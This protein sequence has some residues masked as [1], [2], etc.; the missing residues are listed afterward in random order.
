MND[1]EPKQTII[2]GE[3]EYNFILEQERYLEGFDTR[4]IMQFDDEKFVACVWGQSEIYVID[5]E[6]PDA[7]NSFET[8]PTVGQPCKQNLSIQLLP[9]FDP[10]TFPF[11][12]VLSQQSLILADLRRLQAFII[13]TWQFKSAPHNKN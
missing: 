11:A 6:K 2:G 5:R 3:I 4:C 12:F 1:T 13:S 8:N 10:V 7:V 9:F